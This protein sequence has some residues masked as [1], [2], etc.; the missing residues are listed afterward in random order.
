MLV[1]SFYLI[2]NL[3]YKEIYEQ[4]LISVPAFQQLTQQQRQETYAMKII[5][6][7]GK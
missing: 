7:F 4:V 2:F 6:F 1:Q 3:L 5:F